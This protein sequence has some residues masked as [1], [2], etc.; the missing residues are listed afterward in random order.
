MLESP[1]SSC[2]QDTSLPGSCKKC[3]WNYTKCSRREIWKRESPDWGQDGSQWVKSQSL[4][5]QV[6]EPQ[7]APRMT[8]DWATKV[9]W[10][11][12]WHLKG[13][14]Q[15]REMGIPEMALRTNGVN[16]GVPCLMRCILRCHELWLQGTRKARTSRVNFP[17]SSKVGVLQHQNQADLIR[18][19]K[20]KSRKWCFLFI[21]SW[22]LHN[23]LWWLILCA[24]LMGP[25][26]A[27]IKHYF[28]GCF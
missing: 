23:K 18:S 16:T 2:P 12:V 22:A 14:I 3:W 17:P 10:K 19:I 5:L 26:G 9:F 6:G 24:K 25:W 28:C 13:T 20:I 21:W 8:W 1:N 15:A 27:Q 11:Q 7:V 4:F